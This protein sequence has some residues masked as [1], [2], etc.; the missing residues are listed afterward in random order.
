MNGEVW[1]IE[2]WGELLK[3]CVDIEDGVG[4]RGFME[5]MWILVVGG[6]LEL[7]DNRV[8]FLGGKV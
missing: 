3:G 5:G 2:I 4:N 1:V 7:F 8:G 6:F